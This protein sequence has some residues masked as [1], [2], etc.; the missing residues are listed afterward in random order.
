MDL[1]IRLLAYLSVMSAGFLAISAAFV[2]NAL[3]RDVA[4]EVE[5]STQLAEL[6]LTIGE[7]HRADVT[8]LQQQIDAGKLRHITVF[9]ERSRMEQPLLS[10]SDGALG[11]LAD[12]LVDP[13][14]AG[15][16]ERRIRVGDETLV[17]RADPRSEVNEILNDALRMLGTLLAFSLG[18]MLTAWLAAHHA[19]KPVR[20]LEEGLA[21]LADGGET[22]PRLPSFALR[23]FHR[24]AQAIDRLAGHLAQSRAAEQ[25]LTRRLLELQESE[26]RELAR[27]LHDEFGQSLTAIGI[28]A[29]F[30]ERHAET[31]PAATL[32]DCAHDI[33]AES[34][35]VSSHVR[36]LL[37]QL[38]PH[39]LETLGLV[40]SLRELIEGWR[41]RAPGI[42]LEVELP[43]RL[44]PLSPDAGLA[45]YRSLQ[46]ALTNILRH[47]GADRARIVLEASSTEIRLTV[48]D[49]GS[50]L[51]PE[52]LRGSRCGL[53]GMLERAQMAGGSLHLGEPPGGGLQLDL[54]LPC[55]TATKE[56]PDHDPHPA[57]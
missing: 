51:P 38:R 30:I 46:E 9:L 41:Q 35:R 16:R 8:H 27:E 43:S 48:T 18:T 56:T 15:S 20:A 7:M 45:L 44:P 21:Q 10:A 31:A 24:I 42:A 2:F 14:P 33:R 29:A 53:R 57:P 5:A 39:G 55:T 47:S 19:L 22:R 36:S 54:R 23:E 4:E 1:R 26:R 28:A 52:A 49:N 25:Q 11:A 3:Q 40:D 50:G 34:G 12:R 13:D 37:N 6:M 17:I 32:V